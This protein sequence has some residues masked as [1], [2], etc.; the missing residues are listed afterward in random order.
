MADHPMEG[1]GRLRHR[2]DRVAAQ[3]VVG[4]FRLGEAV[5][6]RVPGALSEMGLAAV[7]Q[8]GALSAADRRLVVE[9]NLR[10]VYGR[11]LTPNEL[12]AKVNATF[13]SYARYYF[14]SFRLT[15][16]SVAEVGDGFT[17][18]GIEHLEEAMADDEVGP[19]LALPHLG[20]W[21]WA[22][23]WITRVRLWRLAAVV[24]RLEPPELF[25]WFLG[26]RRSLGM[27]IIPLGPDAV[28]RV[29][30]AAAN[31]EIVCLLCDRDIVGGGVPVTFFGEDTTLPAGPAVM[32]LR[33]GCRVL[34]TAVYFTAKGV[35]GVVRPPI[36]IERTTSDGIRP[37]VP[38]FMQ[39]LAGELE[40]LIRRAP[41][42]WHLMQ[43]NW[44]SDYAALGRPAP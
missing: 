24:E 3:A 21:E 4:A 17:V 5:A 10:R 44:P 19:V 7:G 36:R 28:T 33:G 11:D 6:P 32:A 1:W 12:R 16:M 18:E 9:R 35:H 13:E 14:D 39:A 34:P 41:E 38:V 2:L 37:D 22:A 43:P 8:V 30:E 25:D 31:R 15:S 29:T 27:N 40:G 26:F 42:Q 23:F 20:G